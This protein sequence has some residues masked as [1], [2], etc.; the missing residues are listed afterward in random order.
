[1]RRILLIVLCLLSFGMS[2]FAQGVAFRM[3]RYD[4]FKVHPVTR[5]N[6][7]FF[8]NSITNMH[9]WW[10]AF[11]NEKVLNRGVNGAETPIMLQHLETVLSGKPDKL[12]FMM[13]TNDL[14]TRGLN[15][16]AQVAKNVR[17]VLMRCAKESPTTKVYFQSI[18]PCKSNGIKNIADIPV[19]NDSIKNICKEYG[20]TYV[21][22][23]DDLNGIIGNKISKDELHLTMVGYR[24][25]CKK[26]A[27]LV[28]S[29]C[30][31]PET[32]TDKDAGLGGIN[33]MRATY[34]AALPMTKDD[35]V[36][37]G[38]DGNDWHELLHSAHV[39]QRGGSWG[40]QNIELSTMKAMI[41]T[42]FKENEKNE[43]PKMVILTL[44]YK[45]VNNAGVDLSTIQTQYEDIVKQIKTL[46]PSSLVKLM[47]VY[48]SPN[49][50]ININRTIKFNAYL[51]SLALGIDGVEYVEGS[52]A[53]LVKD[54]VINSSF[55]SN[56]YMQGM[57]YAKLSQVFAEVIGEGVVPITD[58]EASLAVAT[59]EARTKLYNA[60]ATAQSMKIGS[61]V[62]QYPREEVAPLLQGI[63][64]GYALLAKNDA[65]N[66]VLSQKAKDYDSLIKKVKPL[67]NQPAAS[68]SF[69]EHWYQLYTPN[70]SSRYMTS[71][72]AGKPLIGGEFSQHAATMWKFVA[73]GDGSFDIIN[74]EDNSYINPVATYNS[75]ISTSS[76]RPTKG[77]TVSYANQCGMYIL[78]CG[79]VEINQTLEHLG[80]S[81]Y[82][83]SKNQTGADRDDAGCIFCIVDA[84]ELI[85]DPVS[86]F[87]QADIPISLLTGSF[88]NPSAPFNKLWT[89]MRA[90]PQITF[91][92]GTANNMTNV[93]DNI[94]I[95]PGTALC[96]TY[97]IDAGRGYE[98]SSYTFRFKDH[99]PNTSPL[100]ILV[101]GA[102]FTTSSEQQ[103]LKAVDL[104]AQS[105]SFILKGDNKG[106]ELLDFVV[107]VKRCGYTSNVDIQK[108][109]T[110]NSFQSVFDLHGKRVV[111]Q[112]KGNVYIVN[113]KKIVYK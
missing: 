45:E 104:S 108:N 47:A 112:Q 7:V 63:E 74:R 65:D 25:W 41:P 3:H 33:G 57:G 77:W 54:D 22:L 92:S 46:V 38:D 27:S 88:S 51:Q 87:T 97:T 100:T 30:V 103:T 28:G 13:G 72:G 20:V 79:K 109:V 34:F 6:I 101:D 42:I 32:V 59:Y 73:R 50:D 9:E 49:R 67:I 29:S 12:F 40:Y 23:Y 82:N 14:G 102:S 81:I 76:V 86:D 75:A 2:V 110:T 1:M 10:E 111:R 90:A 44:G 31:Y 68:T 58:E 21:D 99:S 15:T 48:P 36:I 61:D 107:S 18:L 5:E 52:Y 56:N 98:I 78:S 39:K 89:S 80:W 60:I 91:S 106:V 95:Y 16:P 64:E 35:V 53:Q 55:F 85:E 17:D 83:W 8:G 26:I 43:E 113:R 4:G 69:S 11:G 71:Q 96:C 19:T 94:V 105:V 24:I 62:G 37:L 66:N 84:P 70:R 93:D